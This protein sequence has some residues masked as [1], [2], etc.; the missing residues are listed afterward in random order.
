MA[1]RGDGWLIAVATLMANAP[2]LMVYT[3]ND[4]AV[5][6][7]AAFT[8]DRIDCERRDRNGRDHSI[9][10]RDEED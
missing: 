3:P 7:W 10:L 2:E 9:G 6:K 1:R 5:L 4:E 8:V